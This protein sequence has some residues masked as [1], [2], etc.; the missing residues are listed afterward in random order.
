MIDLFVIIFLSKISC[1]KSL[2]IL[3]ENLKCINIPLVCY[4]VRI[5]NK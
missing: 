4:N 2:T 3:I 5:Q 1:A